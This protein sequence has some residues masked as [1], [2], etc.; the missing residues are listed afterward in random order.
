MS[1]FGIAIG[2]WAKT[3]ILGLGSNTFDVY[4]DLGSGIYHQQSKNVTRTFLVNETVQESCFIM[5]NNNTGEGQQYLC[6]E[7]DTIWAAITFGCIQLPA[8]VL[9]LCGAVAAMLIRCIFTDQAEYHAG[10]KTLVAGSLLL[11]II[12]FPLLVFTQQ[13]ASLFIQTDQMEL[14]SATFLFGEGA[15]EASPQLLLLLYI[16]V[17]DAEREIPWIQKA[18]I[19]SSL[20]TISKTAIELFVSESFNCGATPSS[21]L[22]HKGTCDDSMLKGKTLGGKLL[23]MAQL[24]PAFI[25]SLAFKVGSIA[26]ICALLKGYAVIYLAIAIAITFIVAFN[27]YDDGYTTDKK[28]GS[29]L[30]YSLTNTTILSK[31]PLQNRR[32]NYKQM[33]A[34]SITWLILHTTTLVSLM[35]WA[36]ALPESA[37]L[38]HWSSQRFALIQPTIFYPTII[39]ILLLGP[40]SILALWGLKKQVKVLEEKEE[41]ERK[42]WDAPKRQPGPSGH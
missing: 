22:N 4:S 26:I 19:I 12:P 9:A 11:L 30:F 13:V 5:P 10:Y 41:G 29:A 14:L 34:V 16:I 24:S 42:F 40:L 37:H 32:W 27:T 8:V 28:T 36:G 39:C 6:L 7:E 25:L 3:I 23:V 35:I 1:Y 20:L 21:I 18:S 15:L 38:E 31:C 2:H 17:S 33:I